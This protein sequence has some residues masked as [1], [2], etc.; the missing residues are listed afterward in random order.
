MKHKI[1]SFL[2][3]FIPVITCGQFKLT[4][5]ITDESSEPIPFASIAIAEHQLGTISNNDGAFEFLIPSNI[6]KGSVLIRAL[7]YKSKT[8]NISNIPEKSDSLLIQLN[9]VIINLDEIKVKANPEASYIVEQAFKNYYT[10]FPDKPY[11]S[12]GYVRHLEKN[13][14]SSKWL[15]EAAVDIYEPGWNISS[16]LIKT[17]ITEIRRSIDIRN[18]DTTSVYYY[19][20]NKNKNFS[21]NKAYAL[22]KKWEEL[23]NT[24]IKDAINYFDYQKSNY[25]RIFNN[26]NNPLR[27]YMNK[28][29]ILDKK[30]LKKHTFKLDTILFSNSD[31]IFKI[32]IS[33]SNPPAKL[34]KQLDSK[35]L[36]VGWLYV[37]D[38]DFAI[39]QFDYMLLRKNAQD[40]ISRIKGSRLSSFF[41]IR[42]T[43]YESKMYPQYI[44]LKTPKVL[45]LNNILTDL[46]QKENAEPDDLYFLEQEITI[47]KTITDSQQ[48]QKQ[49]NNRNKWDDNLFTKRKF[50]P[51]F[52]QTYN[53][54]T[55]TEKE[56]KQRIE[57]EDIIKKR[58]TMD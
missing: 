27:N 56:K 22:S 31:K 42:F 11:I 13:K 12:K 8:I 9:K 58:K 36:P 33:P 52:W 45:N 16:E 38:N 14:I 40:L 51:E 57:L 28:D 43:E 23:S 6:K 50:N 46:A 5:K 32:K 37:R 10:N 17:N 39:M 49:S 41:S 26:D 34:N 21:H 19:Y 53:T 48:V 1:L 44:S 25:N 2:I 7:G 29:A 24:E 4:G 18:I 20:L 55:E 35:R 47:S 54:T 3:L 15:I 30:L